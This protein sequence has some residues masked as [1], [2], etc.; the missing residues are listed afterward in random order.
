[1]CLD[2]FICVCLQA[3][4]AYVGESVWVCACISQYIDKQYE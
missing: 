3:L 1:M 4:M 2:V